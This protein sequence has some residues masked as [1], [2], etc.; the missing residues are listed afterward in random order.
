M[1]FA[2]FLLIAITF[3]GCWESLHH[4]KYTPSPEAKERQRL[5]AIVLRKAALQLGREK[6]LK[7]EGNG[8]QASKNIQM[9]A[10]SFSYNKSIDVKE[11]RKLL[12]A[13]VN[14]LMDAVNNEKEIH[15]YLCNIPFDPGNVEIRIFIHNPDGSNTKTGE[16]SVISALRGM[17]NYETDTQER[18]SYITIHEETYEE[19]LTKIKL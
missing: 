18:K 4:K 3:V 15:R 17:F 16:L 6:N 8:A 19:A 9:L 14:A 12:V 10:L 11:G 2:L 7:Y 1:K 5:S 13:S